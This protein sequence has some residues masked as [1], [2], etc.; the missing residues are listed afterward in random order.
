[1]VP[2]AFPGEDEDRQF[3]DAVDDPEDIGK[4]PVEHINDRDQEVP[5]SIPLPGEPKFDRELRRE[6]SRIPMRVPIA[7][8]RLHRQSG[9]AP[10][11]ALIQLMR[12]A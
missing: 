1:M 8:R 4:E 2:T 7:I 6:W 12:L 5:E 11:N 9:H 10:S 3:L